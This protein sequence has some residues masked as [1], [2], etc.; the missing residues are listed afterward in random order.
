VT[1]RF[2][3]VHRDDLRGT[4]LHLVLTSHRRTFNDALSELRKH[5]AATAPNQRPVLFFDFGTGDNDLRRVDMLTKE[6]L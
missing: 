3:A 2:F 6:A 4:H 1:V 5:R